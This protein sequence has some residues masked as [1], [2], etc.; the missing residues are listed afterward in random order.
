MNRPSLDRLQRL[1]VWVAFVAGLLGFLA[2]IDLRLLPLGPAALAWLLHPA[3]FLL[4]AAAAVAGAL[5]GREI[6]AWRW[7]MVDAPGVTAGERE[8]AHKSAERQRRRA[9]TAFL[10]GPVFLGYWM[11]Y[12]LAGE[13]ATW[14]LPASALAGYATGFLAA[15]RKLPPE[16]SF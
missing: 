2:S 11:V 15:Q 16:R 12:Q 1:S 8:E 5:R 4:G 6:D 14:L 7:E 3:L 13:L 10:A 9:G